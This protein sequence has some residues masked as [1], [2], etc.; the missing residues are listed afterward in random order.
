MI[1]IQRT[2][3]RWSAAASGAP[4]AADCARPATLPLPPHGADVVIQLMRMPKFGGGMLTAEHF[5]RRRQASKSMM[6]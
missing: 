5:Q 3:A 2:R 1:T 4:H 6:I